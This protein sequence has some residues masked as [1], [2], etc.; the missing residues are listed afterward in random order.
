MSLTQQINDRLRAGALVV[1]VEKAHDA[2]PE[3]A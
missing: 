2:T 3:A 1:I